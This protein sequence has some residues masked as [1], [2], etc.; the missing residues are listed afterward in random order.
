MTDRAP[1]ITYRPELRVLDCTIRDGG[2]INNSKF[3]DDQVKAV[4]A[5]A[6]ASGIDYMEIGTRIRRSNSPRASTARGG[7]ARRRTCGGWSATTRSWR[8]G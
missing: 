7:I 5:A 8:R 1:W 2:L 3:T 4:Y 6:V